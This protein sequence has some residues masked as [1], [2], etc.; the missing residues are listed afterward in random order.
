MQLQHFFFFFVRLH[1]KLSRVSVALVLLF[2]SFNKKIYQNVIFLSPISPIA[3]C[4]W[5]L[6]AKRKLLH[7]H[8]ELFGFAKSKS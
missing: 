5:C 8:V 3:I 6:P 1:K 4:L 7:L 2:N